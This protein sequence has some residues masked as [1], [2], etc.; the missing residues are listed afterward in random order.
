VNHLIAIDEVLGSWQGDD[1]IQFVELRMLAA[2][3]QLLSDGGGVRGPA[4]LIFDDTSGSADTRR[5]FTFTHDLAVGTPDS[6]ILIATQGLA[7]LSGVTPDFI[8]P[9]GMLAPRNG[10]VCYFVNPPQDQSETP[11]VI[12]CVAYG[13]FKGANG[14]FGPPTPL[15]PDDRSLQRETVTGQNAADWSTVLTPTPQ[16]DAGTSQT[17]TTL[18]GDGQI[19]QGE[20]CDGSA[21][22]GMSCGS[23]GFASG[24][25]RCNQCHFDTSRCSFCGNDAIN[26]KEQCD[27][28]DLGG[29]TCASL[30]FTGG[31]L[32]CTSGCK[33]T[34]A[35]CDPTFFVPGSGPTATDCIAEWEV[36]NAAARPD[37]T[38]R[39]P[40]R[41]RCKD[42]DAGCDADTVG[43]QCTFTVAV[44]FDRDDPRLTVDGH[45]C[46]Q[47]AVESWTLLLPPGGGDM[48][49]AVAALGPAS[50]AGSAVTFAPPLDASER[51]TAP[52]AVVVPTH[53]KRAG[54]LALRART[55]GVGGRPRDVDTL[56]LVC[57][58]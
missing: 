53:G 20:E 54:K 27:G 35:G 39:A 51:C 26:G 13:S 19:S 42:G 6:R 10:R 44:C 12:D 18:C 48:V 11:G 43:G 41:Q 21:L 58:P 22:G 45:A 5:F 23:L 57:M 30:G 36:R 40:V 3:Q 14:S 38:G 52:I 9:A 1:T 25:L 31:T 56:K 2:G 46:R 7:D 32:A 28:T 29:L 24:T 55:T 8:M 33:L 4:E 17:L 49:P 34:T 37:A 50:V 16:N 15:T 47:V